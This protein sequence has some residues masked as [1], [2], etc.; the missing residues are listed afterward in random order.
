MHFS[1]NNL[2]THFRADLTHFIANL[3]FFKPN[4]LKLSN[5]GLNRIKQKSLNETATR[6]NEKEVKKNT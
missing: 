6:S 3:T 1:P 5:R 4:C 2:E